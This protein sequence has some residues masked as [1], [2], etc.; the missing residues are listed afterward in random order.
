MADMSGLGIAFKEWAVICRALIQGR[1]SLILRKGGI[2]ETVGEF[3]PEH[4]RFWLFPTWVHQQSSGVVS[5]F[6]DLWKEV[7]ADRPPEGVVPLEGW[8][9]V[10]EVRRVDRLESVLALAGLH[11]WS[12][13]TVRA[14]F[15]YR[16]PG[17]YVLLVRVY[18][19]DRPVEL[20]DTPYYAGCRTWVRLERAVEAL[21]NP[22]LSA[23]AFRE[24]VEQVRGRLGDRSEPRA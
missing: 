15:H 20:P 22:V 14:R 7:E 23:E 9:E 3:R 24:Q 11:G 12:E 5:E 19:L 13:E 1:Q 18:R 10:A 16:T 4:D 2:A 8:V 21:G 6:Q 17:L